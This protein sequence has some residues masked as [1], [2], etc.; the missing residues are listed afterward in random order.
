MNLFNKIISLFWKPSLYILNYNLLPYNDLISFLDLFNGRFAK[1]HF[2]LSMVRRLRWW[3]G[4]GVRS[5]QFRFDSKRTLPIS[6]RFCLQHNRATRRVSS[7][8]TSRSHHLFYQGQSTVLS[9]PVLQQTGHNT[10]HLYSEL[11]STYWIISIE[12]I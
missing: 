5:R 1:V 3:T 12:V 7:S 4:L 8:R 2:L 9:K 10:G 11:Y 6:S